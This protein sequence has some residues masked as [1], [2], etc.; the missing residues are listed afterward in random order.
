MEIGRDSLSLV[1]TFALLA[2][3]FAAL[4]SLSGCGG[5][6]LTLAGIAGDAVAHA[7]TGKSMLD[8]AVSGVTAR[9]CEVYRVL[10]GED[11]CRS[12]T[13]AA[14]KAAT[15]EPA[16]AMAAAAPDSMPVSDVSFDGRDGRA[17]T[18][19]PVASGWVPLDPSA[20]AADGVTMARLSP[21]LPAAGPP[22]APSADAVIFAAAGSDEEIDPGR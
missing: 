2:A 7:T 16:V 17:V 6:A 3:L 12:A 10:D 20:D 14:P 5:A 8:A 19:A 4:A 18:W 1:R 22:S 9:D 11:P 21:A 15:L 13:A